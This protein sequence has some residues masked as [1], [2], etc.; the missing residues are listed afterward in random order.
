LEENKSSR[1]DS[2]MK[3]GAVE[4]IGD[5]EGKFAMDRTDRCT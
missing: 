2:R 5:K 1:S 4:S 3:F